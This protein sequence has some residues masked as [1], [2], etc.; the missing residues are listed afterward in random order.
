MSTKILKNTIQ[1]KKKRKA[2]IV[3]DDVI[4]DMISNKKHNSVVTELYIRGRKINVSHI[5]II[6]S[7]FKVS[8]NVRLNCTLSFILKIPNKRELQQIAINH[9]SDIDFKGFMKTCK[10]FTAEP[11]SFLVHDKTLS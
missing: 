5:F 3:F 10:K 8:R 9:S 2:L 6:Q 7:Y 11:F 4:A 1:K